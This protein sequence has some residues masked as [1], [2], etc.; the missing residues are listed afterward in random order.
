MVY[1]FLDSGP[2][3]PFS[4]PA[5][6]QECPYSI[7]KTSLNDSKF[8]WSSREFARRRL[9]H[10][11]RG[12]SDVMVGLL[13]GHHLYVQIS[14]RETSKCKLPPTSKTVM[15]YAYISELGESK[16]SPTHTSGANQRY[17]WM[18]PWLCVNGIPLISVTI[19]A[20][21]V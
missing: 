16:P 12:M 4:R 21:L 14:Q 6:G 2:L 11:L 3:F 17:D 10:D 18:T 5:L 13:V 1:D 20:V 9:D 7:S 15:L 19:Y 8:C